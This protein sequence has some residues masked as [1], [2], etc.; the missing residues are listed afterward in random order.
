MIPESLVKRFERENEIMTIPAGQV[1][2][3]FHKYIR[4]IPII[5]SGSV[6]VLSEDV[7]GKEMTLYLIK[8][9]ESCIMSILGAINDSSSLVKAVTLQET[10]VVFIKPEEAYNLIAENKEWFDFIM[11]LYQSRFEELVQQVGRL[12]FSSTEDRVLNLLTTRSRVLKSK[13]LSITHQQIADE[14]GTARE[15]V[16]RSMKIMENKGMIKIFRG[17]VELM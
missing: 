9:G 7:D 10:Q 1:L 13:I 8:P 17:K 11:K 12:T 3:D 14:V 2:L 15:V 5:L 4:N 6:R 16:S